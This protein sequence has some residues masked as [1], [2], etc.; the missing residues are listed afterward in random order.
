MLEKIQVDGFKSLTSFALDI[1]PGLN[2][3]VGP[4][5]SGKSNIILFFE[6]LSHLA[7]GS[8][9][10]AISRIGGA[11]AVF[12]LLGD[13]KL[14]SQFSFTVRGSGEYRVRHRHLKRS[15]RTVS[16]EYHAVIELTLELAALAFKRQE[17]RIIEGDNRQP[18]LNFETPPSALEIIWQIDEKG[19]PE[20]QVSAPDP[21]LFSPLYYRPED[22]KP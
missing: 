11:G 18:T 8:V 16:Y 7:N 17:L 2:I 5:G 21:T 14:L 20:S 10:Q 4:N 6:F 1:K 19:D 15:R 12:P 9:M 3:L 22:D 13:G